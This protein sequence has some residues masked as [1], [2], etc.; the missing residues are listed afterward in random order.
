VA[1]VLYPETGWGLRQLDAFSTMW[2]SLGGTLAESS[3][4]QA[5]GQDHS[6]TVKLL[7]N[8]DESETRHRELQRIAGQ[9]LEF[10]PKKRQD[11]D[12][13]FLIARSGQGRLLKPQINF[14]A[15]QDVPVY[16]ISQVYSGGDPVKDI[17]LDDVVFGDMP[18]LIRD[19][20]VNRA[21]R[22]ELPEGDK[23]RDDPLDRL[24]ALGIDTYQMLFRLEAMRN[25]PRL[26]F[27]GTTGVLS[28]GADGTIVRRLDWAR[29]ADGEAKPVEWDAALAGNSGRPVQ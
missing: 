15:A 19:F 1:A 29:F 14:H 22:E 25:N 10:V 20:G 13:I 28:L 6:Q 17:D 5:E 9:S 24:F 11:L 16:A 12:Y 3:V 21:I 8:L 27:R 7:L 4:Y 2:Q 23:Y 18:W 26:E